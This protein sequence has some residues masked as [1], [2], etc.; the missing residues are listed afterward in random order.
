MLAF[1]SMLCSAAKQAGIPVPPDN[2]LD[3]GSYDPSEYPQW[4]VLCATQL[5]RAMDHGEHF[6]NAVELAK[7][8]IEELKTLTWNQLAARH[9]CPEAEE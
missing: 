1:P 3:D 8:D 9:I 4:H 6:Q 2:T 5:G 7:I